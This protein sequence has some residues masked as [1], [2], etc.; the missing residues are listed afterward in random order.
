M[1]LIFTVLANVIFQFFT[2]LFYIY[3]YMCVYIHTEMVL[4]VQLFRFSDLNQAY[5][6]HLHLFIHK[7]IRIHT[8]VHAHLC[9]Q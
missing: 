7:H 2:I 8:S 1:I 5:F 3:I 4:I 9:R 6:G